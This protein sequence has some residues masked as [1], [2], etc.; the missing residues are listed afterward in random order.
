MS[1]LILLLC[2]VLGVV[3]AGC[4]RQE[5]VELPNGYKVWA[6]NPREI[7]LANAKDELVVGFAI[8]R[9]GI[10]S[11]T[12]VI[13]CVNHAETV[14]GFANMSGYSIVDTNSGE[15]ERGLDRETFERR[16]KEIEFPITAMRP[17]SDF[18]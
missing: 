14:N 4:W 11:Q 5:V 16:A 7:Y 18:F 13:E 9:V 2:L 1:R 10:D 12:I 8:A 3:A 15:I 6:M 17:V